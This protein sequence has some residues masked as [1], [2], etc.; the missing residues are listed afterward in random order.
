VTQARLDTNKRGFMINQE[1]GMGR[2]VVGFITV[3]VM[4]VASNLV[5]NFI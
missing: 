1:G 2:D 5:L 4:R 3:K